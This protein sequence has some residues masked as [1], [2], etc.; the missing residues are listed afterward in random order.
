[1]IPT[2]LIIQEEVD[3]SNKNSHV[4]DY[5]KYYCQLDREPCYAVLL[6][7]KWGTGKTWFIKQAFESLG[8][9]KCNDIEKPS[10]FEKFFN[11]VKKKKD[12]KTHTYM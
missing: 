3:M 9:S 5:L 1:M 2:N 10:W 11:H 12:K 6:K 4:K 7:G 8:Y